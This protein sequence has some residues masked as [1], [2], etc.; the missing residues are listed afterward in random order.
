MCLL[1]AVLTRL[2]LLWNK[3]VRVFDLFPLL[4]FYPYIRQWAEHLLI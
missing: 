1:C 4:S 3:Q 2:I